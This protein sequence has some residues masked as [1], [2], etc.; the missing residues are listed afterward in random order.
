MGPDR[1]LRRRHL[2]TPRPQSFVHPPRTP[3]RRRRLQP[4]HLPRDPPPIPDPPCLASRRCH[5]AQRHRRPRRPVLDR[6][7]Q[8][9]HRRR[10]HPQRIRPPP[11]DHRHPLRPLFVDRRLLRV[12]DASK[13]GRGKGTGTQAIPRP[14][15]PAPN[16]GLAHVER[17]LVERTH[18]SPHPRNRHPPRGPLR[19]RNHRPNPRL[20][21]RPLRAVAPHHPPHQPPHRH[22]TPRPHRLGHLPTRLHLRGSHPARHRL[23]RPQ[24]QPAEQTP[25]PRG[26]PTQHCLRP[27]LLRLPPLHPRWG[28]P[29]PGAARLRPRL[30]QPG[31]PLSQQ[32]HPASP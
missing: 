32:R 8:R 28:V 1:R 20:R 30:R 26:G 14:S 16:P 11:T 21:T 31:G 5:P 27:T 19:R 12:C 3:R 29:H 9:R 6:L 13:L 17:Q 10:H 4:P 15:P 22:P 2:R 24:G 18:A 23:L 25:S 7:D